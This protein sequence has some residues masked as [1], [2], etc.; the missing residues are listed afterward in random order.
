MEQMNYATMCSPIASQRRRVACMQAAAAIAIHNEIIS[1]QV[2]LLA[3]FILRKIVSE[4]YKVSTH[5]AKAKQQLSGLED[6]LIGLKVISI[7]ENNNN[8]KAS[9]LSS[10]NSGSSS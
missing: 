6:N 10:F 1:T 3:S 7:C 5:S 2:E 9:Q 8:S 4:E